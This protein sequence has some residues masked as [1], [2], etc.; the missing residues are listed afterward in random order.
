MRRNVS[1]EVQLH[2]VSD[3]LLLKCLRLHLIYDILHA[4]PDD[5]APAHGSQEYWPTTDCGRTATAPVNVLADAA[6]SQHGPS[7]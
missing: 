2:P 7:K 6:Q 1:V 4:E 3:D 5:S